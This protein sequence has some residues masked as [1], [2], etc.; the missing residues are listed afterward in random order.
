MFTVEVTNVVRT[1]RRILMQNAMGNE[2]IHLP[3]HLCTSYC[4]PLSVVYGNFQSSCPC[5]GS[6]S[7][8][9][10]AMT[11]YVHNMVNKLPDYIATS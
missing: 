4:M 1:T 5:N 6:F 7:P 8:V 10:L 11:A 2:C 9:V 3:T